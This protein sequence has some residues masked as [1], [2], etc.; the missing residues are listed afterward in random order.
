MCRFLGRERGSGTIVALGLIAALMTLLA[1]VVILGAASAAKTQAGR[2]SDLAALAAADTA[3][4]LNSGD[5]CTV[6]EQVAQRNGSM[7]AECTVGGEFPTEVTVTVAREVESA[8][9]PDALPLGPLT[10]TVSSRAGP[11]EASL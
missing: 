10:A 3:R 4:G 6:A 1:L 9:L 5:P 8:L 2:A 7:L 11:P